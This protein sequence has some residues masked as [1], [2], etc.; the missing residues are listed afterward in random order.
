M[1][2][3]VTVATGGVCLSAR[4]RFVAAM[5][6]VVVVVVVVAVVAVAVAVTVAGGTRLT[7]H[8][9]GERVRQGS[10]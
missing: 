3:S 6:V 9:N 5:V 1:H 10:F 7:S 2:L 4:A 8:E